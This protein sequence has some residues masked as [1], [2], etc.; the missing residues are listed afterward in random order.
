MTGGG[1]VCIFGPRVA[2]VF[3]GEV[4]G[5]A[6]LQ[7]A[8]LA[9]ALTAGGVRC[10]I[11]DPHAAET[12]DAPAGS[13]PV[14]PVAGWNTGIRGLRML[15]RRVPR[16]LRA[17]R[18]AHPSLYYARGFSALSAVPW[19][20][21]RLEGVPFV[22]AVASDA[23]LLAFRDRFESLYRG[24]SRIWDWISTIIPN[25]LTL[26]FLQRSADALLVQH[27]GQV[28]LA[29]RTGLRTVIC[30]N[31]A[32]SELLEG[33]GCGRHDGPVTMVGTLSRYKG[34]DRLP[35]LIRS[36][37][38]VTFEF[39]GRVTDADGVKAQRSLSALPNV[40]ISGALLRAETLRRIAKAR[41]LLNTSPWE[42]FPNTF[43]EAWA[44][45]TPVLSLHVDPG[46]ILERERLGICCHG[47]IDRLAEELRRPAHDLD[48]ERIRAYVRDHH[49]GA[50]AV[51]VLTQLIPHELRREY[52]A[53]TTGQ[54]N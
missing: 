30:R 1:G 24:R 3:S 23:N 26:A 18:A 47:D 54:E 53:R 2:R 49:S 44:F 4:K 51:A 48:P 39:I 34:L 11:V 42:G 29:A 17:L 14:V 33:T 43:L 50:A 10:V 28:S 16:L 35:D 13:P 27:E 37:P 32:G 12:R 52:H 45:G 46:G 6:E 25:E 9:Q 40:R 8:L 36:L 31:I 19:L 38:D 20:A 7:M 41:A 21:A 5:G 15:T 22:L